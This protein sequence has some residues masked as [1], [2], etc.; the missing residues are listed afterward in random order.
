MGLHYS[1]IVTDIMLPIFELQLWDSA[2]DGQ[3]TWQPEDAR[4]MRTSIAP[5]ARST[6]VCKLSGRRRLTVLGETHRVAL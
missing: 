6:H 2:S 5:L 3:R 1:M 4:S